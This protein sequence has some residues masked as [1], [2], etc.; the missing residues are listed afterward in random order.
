M[1]ETE[2][3]IER[4]CVDRGRLMKDLIGISPKL[5]LYKSLEAKKLDLDARILALRQKLPARKAQ[6]PRKRALMT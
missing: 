1:N 6:E 4:L 2:R 5:S 3:Q